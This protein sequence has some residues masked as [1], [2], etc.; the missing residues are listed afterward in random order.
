[1]P[2]KRKR[3]GKRREREEKKNR[4]KYQDLKGVASP[5]SLSH[6]RAGLDL[7]HY[8]G[9]PSAKTCEAWVYDNSGARGL[10]CATGPSVPRTGRQ[11][12]VAIHGVLRAG[13]QYA[14]TPVPPLAA[15]V[16]QP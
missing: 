2:G 8:Y 11:I 10:P 4:R 12:R 13:I 5:C 9:R 3:G 14:N 15:I 1:M 7:F 16:L 6:G